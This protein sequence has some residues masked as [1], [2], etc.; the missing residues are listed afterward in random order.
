MRYHVTLNTLLGISRVTLHITTPY[1]LLGR[2]YK[3]MNV[4]RLFYSTHD[5][6]LT[7]VLCNLLQN[8]LGLDPSRGSWLIEGC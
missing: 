4:H 2:V 3:L 5:L 7:Y 8:S 6:H 1:S